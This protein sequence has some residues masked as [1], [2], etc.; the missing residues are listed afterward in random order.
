M[1][2]LGG[3]FGLAYIN[4]DLG[5]KALGAVMY[6]TN[7]TGKQVHMKR[8]ISLTKLKWVKTQHYLLH[9]YTKTMT[10]LILVFQSNKTL[11]VSGLDTTSKKH[12]LKVLPFRVQAFA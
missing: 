4:A 2:A 12:F 11:C 5:D 8:S 6:P 7:G 9:M 3:K 1:K 10:E